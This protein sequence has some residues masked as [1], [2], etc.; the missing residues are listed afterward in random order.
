MGVATEG[1]QLPDVPEWSSALN[2]EVGGMVMSNTYGF[3]RGDLQF[4]GERQSALGPGSTE[5][6]SYTLLNLKAGLETGPYRVSLFA[7]NLTDERAELSRYSLA[8][9]R[10]GELLTLDRVT[11][12][13]P[14]T[15]GVSISREF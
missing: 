7:N 11:V 5:L 14:R 9:V 4:V 6:S 13:R 10:Q 2:A 8:G 15:I 1:Q 3:V 12:N